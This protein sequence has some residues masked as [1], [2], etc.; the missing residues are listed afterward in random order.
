MLKVKT[1]PFFHIR[2]RRRIGYHQEQEDYKWQ[3]AANLVLQLETVS[4]TFI[5]NALL[6]PIAKYDPMQGASVSS[7]VCTQV[8]ELTDVSLHRKSAIS[9]A[10]EKAFIALACWFNTHLLL[11]SAFCSDDQ[12]LF[13]NANGTVYP[14]SLLGYQVHFPGIRRYTVSHSPVSVHLPIHRFISKILDFA[15]YADLE[16]RDVI[17]RLIPTLAFTLADFPLRCLSFCAQ[18]RCG[19]W[20]RNGSMP[21][22]LAY[23]Y[24]RPPLCKSLRNTD[25]TSIQ[26]A[27]L[28]LGPDTILALTVDRY[29][30]T[31]FLVSSYESKIHTVDVDKL[32]EYRGPLLADLL[33]TL[34]LLMTYL[35]SSLVKMETSVL[36]KGRNGEVEEEEEIDGKIMLSL[37]REISHL[38]L[39]GGPT[40]SISQL[41][42]AKNMIGNSEMVTDKMMRSAVDELCDKREDPSVEKNTLELRPLVFELFDPEFLNLSSQKQQLAIDRVREQRKKSSLGSSNPK[43]GI[44]LRIPVISLSAIPI[45][46]RDY[47][48]TRR[49]LF[50]PLVCSIL[51]I[52]LKCCLGTE[53]VLGGSVST[54]INRVIHIA[55]LQLHCQAEVAAF[56]QRVKILS[57][58]RGE[59]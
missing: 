14:I 48:K 23:N 51:E 25:L 37:K 33:K 42:K 26:T 45:P 38:L 52:C 36:E 5:C 39:A 9:V 46:H 4:S 21:E 1:F 8:R 24:D 28:V 27:M 59:L 58:E 49:M 32:L 35:P 56:D 7:I 54:V 13:F 34:V 17:I 31:S 41:Q 40:M 43:G 29:E 16:L 12:D 57:N 6:S 2:F 20:R 15:A 50:Q 18:V 19:M 30:L 10:L 53:E 22:N 3:D 55:T 47:T 11:P 44:P